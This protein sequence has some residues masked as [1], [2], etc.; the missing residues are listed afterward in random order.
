MND[1][2]IKHLEFIQNVI[3]RM[4]QNSFLLKGWSV[5]LVSAIFALAAKD[6]NHCYVLLSFF[7]VIMFWTLDGYYLSKER[8]FRDLYKI[9]AVDPD[10]NSDFTMDVSLCNTDKNTWLNSSFAPT[11]YLFHGGII[12]VILIVMFLIPFIS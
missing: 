2:K 8:Q 11:N 7:P 12:F 10:S 1:R 6:S 5:T 9:V 4:A 3:M